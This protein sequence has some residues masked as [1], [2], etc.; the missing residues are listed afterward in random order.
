MGQLNTL[1]RWSQ[2]D[3]VDAAELLPNDLVYT[4]QTNRNLF[5]DYPKWVAAAFVPTLRILR[6][7]NTVTLS[8]TNEAPRDGRVASARAGI[9]VDRCH[10]RAS[11]DR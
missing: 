2:A 1:L 4:F 7:G 3:P 8:W 6:G 9:R 11:I 10:K 5:V